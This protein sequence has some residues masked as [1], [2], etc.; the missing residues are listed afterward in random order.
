MNKIIELRQADADNVVANGDYG[1]TLKY[2]N[3]F[4]VEEGD[5]LMVKNIFVDTLAQSNQKIALPQDVTLEMEHM[6]YYIYSRTD[7]IEEPL[8]GYG[9]DT[10]DAEPWIVCYDVNKGQGTI[11]NPPTKTMTGITIRGNYTSPVDAGTVQ[12]AYKDIDGNDKTQKFD[13]PQSPSRQDPDSSIGVSLVYLASSDPVLTVLSG[14]GDGRPPIFQEE[15]NNKDI[16]LSAITKET[17][18]TIEQGNYTPEQLVAEF[19]RLVQSAV[20]G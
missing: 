19:N 1:L 10:I 15:A 14:G 4:I 9:V 8:A 18:I 16:L 17:R 2:T 6:Y 12:V 5:Q 7:D 13:F 3:D 20:K 11:P